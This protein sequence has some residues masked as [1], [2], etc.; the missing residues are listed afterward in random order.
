[1]IIVIVIMVT[2]S[3]PSQASNVK[4]PSISGLN[5]GETSV[6]DM[7]NNAKHIVK[8]PFQ[9][10][11]IKL[12]HVSP[13]NLLSSVARR[14]RL[15]VGSPKRSDRMTSTR[16]GVN[17]SNWPCSPWKIIAKYVENQRMLEVLWSEHYRI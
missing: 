7:A 6:Q 11:G 13:S 2:K 17:P 10:P 16:R 12:D 14:L 9:D 4:V 8:Y 5:F 1:M 15:C 3:W